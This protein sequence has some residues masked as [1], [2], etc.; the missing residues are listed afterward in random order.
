[1]GDRMPHG[2]FDR[3]ATSTLYVGGLL[4]RPDGPAPGRAVYEARLELRA[5]Y[6]SLG[7]GGRWDPVTGV[8]PTLSF[9]WIPLAVQGVELQ[10]GAG[11][12]L[13]LNKR[14]ATAN[15][16][17]GM[18][19]PLDVWWMPFRVPGAQLCVLLLSGYMWSDTA[20]MTNL[21]AWAPGIGIE[22]EPW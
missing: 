10:L 19:L 15:W 13:G 2:A 20:A 9:R 22:W 4:V 3:R 17:L 8:T 1:M 14:F 11:L 12:G 18:T 6:F 7:G 16:Y 5:T 21:S